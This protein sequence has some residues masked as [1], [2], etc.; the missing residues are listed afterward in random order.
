MSPSSVTPASSLP[1]PAPPVLPLLGPG[2]AAPGS[3]TAEAAVGPRS[4][5]GG[6][7]HPAVPG[8]DRAPDPEGLE[9][10][11]GPQP[12]GPSRWT[13]GAGRGAA[14]RGPPRAPGGDRAT[15]APRPVLLAAA[16]TVGGECLRPGA[17]SPLKAQAPARGLSPHPP[18]TV[19][20]G[21]PGNLPLLC[22]PLVRLPP[23]AE[24]GPPQASPPRSLPTGDLPGDRGAATGTGPAEP[25]R[26]QCLRLA[27]ARRAG[28]RGGLRRRTRGAPSPRKPASLCSDRG[29]AGR[30]HPEAG[31]AYVH[32]APEVPEHEGERGEGQYRNQICPWPVA[33][34][35]AEIP[36]DSH[37][38][39]PEARTRRKRGHWAPT[40]PSAVKRGKVPS[41]RDRKP[42]R[43]VTPFPD[44]HTLDSQPLLSGET[45]FTPDVRIIY[46]QIMKIS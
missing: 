42:R 38:R 39:L 25:G 1:P 4:G 11:H 40:V 8:P 46:L 31:P 45:S 36:Q 21:D 16:G 23:H 34:A 19:C 22:P 30:C 7:R 5:L 28:G 6:G 41:F 12:L 29:P 14:G 26:G 33:P 3:F 37:P 13:R 2:A 10:A 32:P 20:L 15:A 9:H 27:G 17:P 18:F 35:P 43:R 24:P 44:G